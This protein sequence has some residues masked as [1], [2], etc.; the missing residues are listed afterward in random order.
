MSDSTTRYTI[1]SN[2]QINVVRKFCFGQLLCM[3]ARI[4]V[5]SLCFLRGS[6]K[7]VLGLFSTN[8][9]PPGDNAISVTMTILIS[10]VNFKA[11]KPDFTKVRKMTNFCKK[12][13]HSK[14]VY[15]GDLD[16]ID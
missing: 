13:H 2:N 11:K 14:S 8:H 10:R 15:V 16:Y 4:L 7:F 9:Q 6:D 1:T 12:Y 3:K 5:S